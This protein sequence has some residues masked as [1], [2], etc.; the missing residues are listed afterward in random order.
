MFSELNF[1]IHYVFL[2]ASVVKWSEFLA[3]DPEVRVQ[4][5]A[6]SHFLRSSGSGT[7]STQ[8][9]NYNWGATWKK[10]KR[11]RSI[12]PRLRP[13]GIFRADHAIPFYPQMLALTSPTSGGRLVGIFRWRTQATKFVWFFCLLVHNRAI[14]QPDSSQNL[15]PV[16]LGPCSYENTGSLH[17]LRTSKLNKQHSPPIT[18][19][20][21]AESWGAASF[22]EK[23]A[24]TYKTNLS[25][26]ST[27]RLCKLKI[28][29]LTRRM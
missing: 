9:R 16:S 19:W 15:N 22:S 12:K 11:L 8:P 13:Q 20:L 24:T 6:L 14:Q 21:T 18:R 5:P 3:T 27:V 26:V 29:L 10:K 7:G 1:L 17:V 23:L 25:P 2:T 28:S 4:F